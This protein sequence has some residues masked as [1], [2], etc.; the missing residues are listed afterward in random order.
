MN[1][2]GDPLIPFAQQWRDEVVKLWNDGQPDRLPTAYV[3]YAAGY[4]SLEMRYGSEPWRLERLRTLKGQYDPNNVFAWY[5]P[6]IPPA[7]S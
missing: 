4:E 3:N 1:E 5:N 6:V 2:T 7:G